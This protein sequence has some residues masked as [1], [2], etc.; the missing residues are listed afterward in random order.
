MPKFRAGVH[1]QGVG[2]EPLP[3][4]GLTSA[5]AAARLA[6]DGP[7]AVAS[8]SRTSPVR[9]LGALL[10]NPL[11]LLLL[12]LA[13]VAT[14]L[15]DRR[16][17]VV[18]VVMLVIGVVLRFVR[19]SR[20][21][22]AATDLQG[23][24]RVSARVLRDGAPR[25]VPLAEVVVGD[26][27]LLAAGD[28]I[29]GDGEVLVARDLY[30]NEASLTGESL[31]VGKGKSHEAAAARARV[32]LGTSVQSGT[33][34]MRVTATGG[35]TEFGRMAGSL[36]AVELPTAFDRGIGRFTWLMVGFVATMAPIVFV[37]TGVTKGDW[38]QA[39]F[40]AL[41]V[42]VGLTPE[43]LSAIVSVCLTSGA[44]ALSRRKVI[45]R[46]LDAIQ[47]FG[48]MDVLCTD[49]T[50]TLTQ[51]VVV[52]QR[53]LDAG[54]IDS[55]R[56]LRDATLV[57]HFQT[58]LRSVLDE[59]ILT[60]ATELAPGSLEGWGRLDER[61]FDFERRIM[62][63]LV[64]DPG[65]V[66][67]L[68]AKG[69][70]EAVLARCSTWMDGE[71]VAPLDADRAAAITAQA[72]RLS[73]DGFRVL[74][75]AVRPGASMEER[76]LA[77]VGHC[78]F[79]DPPKDS[80]APA[81]RALS[82]GGVAVKVLTGDDVHVTQCVCRAV[83]IP[84]AAPLTGTA[85]D[86][87]D[88]AALADAAERATIFARMT[89]AHKARVIRALQARRHV[90]GFLGD[91]INDAPAL[92]A[93]DVGV[94][95][96]SASDVAKDSADIILLDKSLQ[97]LEAGMRE[98]RKVFVNVLKYLRMGASSN[99]GNMLS[100]LGAS[101]LLPFVP[102]AP[103]QLLTK[104]LLYD[105][106]QVPIPGDRVD[107]EDVA[108]PRPWDVGAIARYI[109]GVGPLSS[110]FDYVTFAAMWWLFGARSP[111][112]ASLFQ[113]GW[114][115]ESVAS[116]TLV[117]HVIRTNRVPFLQSR[118]SGALMG[119]TVAVVAAAAALP[120]TGLGRTLGLVPLPPRYWGVLA[121]T[122]VA[123][124]SLTWVVKGWLVRRGWA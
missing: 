112:E 5:E 120:F 87:M 104:N 118:A 47:N 110:I 70:P 53:H 81:L 108:R 123:Y 66:P 116:Q 32:R 55:A 24:I 99:V 74:A 43:L 14:A 42:A 68:V 8:Q 67:V 82:A 114:F 25:A 62:S 29:P 71:R 69:A 107:D 97:V 36:A 88:D 23:L 22:R 54:G 63:V 31:P 56:V 44:V 3:P 38:G 111:A 59:A 96:D 18:M 106:S 60:H 85:I 33:A 2:T 105:L 117:I 10:A 45:V 7:N 26:V 50:G 101:A 57:S 1:D 9:R 28:L 21:D 121:G 16:S 30:V 100:V 84:D 64:G 51:D 77:F 52:L 46:R 37:V 91:G 103:I 102:M 27:A 34:T 78:A 76:G 65:G 86:A 109:A 11:A 98:G 119:T 83:G 122:L 58:G 72:E 19:E 48:A 61:P 113:T 4:T 13:S 40:F 94:S 124:L 6:R 17:A 92:R 12:V 15:G 73:R 39:L 90:V 115:V 75:V 41:A 49:K 80:A 93:A 20:A 95:V 35:R 89:P 79:L